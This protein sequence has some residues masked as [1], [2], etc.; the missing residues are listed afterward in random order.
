MELAFSNVVILSIQLISSRSCLICGATSEG[1]NS[2][3]ES[4]R[5]ANTLLLVRNLFF[6][7]RV[8]HF[9]DGVLLK[10]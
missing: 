9:S 4:C 1:A 10:A 8:L 5:F 7:E 2:G 6:I 3:V